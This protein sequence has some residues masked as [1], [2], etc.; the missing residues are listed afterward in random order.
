MLG[1]IDVHR[2][3]RLHQM[4]VSQG[5]GDDRPIVLVLA[6]PQ[7]GALPLGLLRGRHDQFVVD[8]GLTGA[9][10]GQRQSGCIQD[11][12]HDLAG[13]LPGVGLSVG[14]RQRQGQIDHV[15]ASGLGGFG[16]LGRI[17]HHIA[18]CLIEQ[19]APVIRL[20]VA[21]LHGQDGYVG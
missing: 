15:G 8:L 1:K 12:A 5:A 20:V 6:D 14:R 16:P 7:E 21:N 18:P 4:F 9:D 17:V 2:S 19:R 3:L 11:F 10:D 13:V